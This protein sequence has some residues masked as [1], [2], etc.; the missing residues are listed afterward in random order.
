MLTKRGFPGR[1]SLGFLQYNAETLGLQLDIHHLR[2]FAACGVNA[3]EGYKIVTGKG[4][5]LTHAFCARLRGMSVLCP[6][7]DLEQNQSIIVNI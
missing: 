7:I 6:A 4:F 1:P 5:D 2:G 3:C